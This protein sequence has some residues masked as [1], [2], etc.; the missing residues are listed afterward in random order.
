MA[1][2]LPKSP[3]RY[4]QAKHILGVIWVISVSSLMGILLPPERSMG[5]DAGSRYHLSLLGYTEKEIHDM[6]SGKRSR[7]EIDAQLLQDM[8]GAK[9]EGV[10]QPSPPYKQEIKG[11]FRPRWIDDQELRSLQAKAYPFLSLVDLASQE[12]SLEKSLILAMIKVESDFDPKA[13]SSKGA[14]GLMQLMPETAKALGIERPFDPWQNIQGGC[15]YLDMC[16]KEFN[17]LHLALA[18][19][20]AGPR[21]VVKAGGIPEIPETKD[22]L[23]KVA[24]YQEVFRYLLSSVPQSGLSLEYLAGPR[25]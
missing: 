21:W 24:A 22:Y 2:S 17:T 12:T 20:N 5:M 15:R 25:R 18:A 23:K 13:V 3:E 9:R 10:P 8:L 4:G 16:L 19:Y 11:P 7:H 6:V 1:S 14:M